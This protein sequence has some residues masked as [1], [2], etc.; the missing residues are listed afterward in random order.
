MAKY[1]NDYGLG[2]QSASQARMA[3]RA[4]AA[5]VV[6]QPIQKRTGGPRCA[7]VRPL[8]VTVAV[9]TAWAIAWLVAF[10]S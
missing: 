9:L 2:F 4:E 7:I 3:R 5:R 8:A 10:A 6:C 1:S